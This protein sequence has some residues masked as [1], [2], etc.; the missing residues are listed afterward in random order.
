MTASRYASEFECEFADAV[1]SVF[2][3]ADVEAALDPTLTP[4][5]TGRW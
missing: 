2:A 3:Y 1:D 4:L 5:F